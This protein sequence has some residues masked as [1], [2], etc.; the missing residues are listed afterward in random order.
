MH[1]AMITRQDFV[2]LVK[3]LQAFLANE[4]PVDLVLAASRVLQK[5]TAS[6]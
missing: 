2:V 1:S 4:R 3:I 6:T 5:L